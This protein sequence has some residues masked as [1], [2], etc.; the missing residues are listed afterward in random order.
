MTKDNLHEA[1][2]ETFAFALRKKTLGHTMT[3]AEHH[4]R[5]SIRQYH[6]EIRIIAEHDY[7]NSYA[8][9]VAT[10]MKKLLAKE[11][12]KTL[13]HKPRFG[14][15]DRFNG[16]NI[17]MRAEKNVREQHQHHI[18]G[19]ATKES[20]DMDEFFKRVE[21]R[22]AMTGTAKKEFAKATD[23]RSGRDRRQSLGPS[24]SR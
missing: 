19:L 22:N 2:Q 7:S 15:D 12:A 20:Q 21:Q 13:D 9:R 5:I 17:Q 6:K 8:K 1:L 10:E 4:E 18:A 14:R 24:R 11:G 16:Q 3:E 23:R